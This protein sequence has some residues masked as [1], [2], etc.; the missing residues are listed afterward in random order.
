LYEG[1]VWETLLFISHHNLT[2][3][4]IIV[5]RNKYGILGSTEELL[6]I[7]PLDKKFESFGFCVKTID[8][9]DFEA[10]NSTFKTSTEQP[11]VVIA[12]TIKGKGVSYMEDK[13]EYHT[14]IPKSQK[15]IEQGISELS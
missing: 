12:N 10:L 7:N 2:N 15:D 1:S 8:G 13:Y 14:I 9:H 4:K 11:L 5:D 6:K 3:I